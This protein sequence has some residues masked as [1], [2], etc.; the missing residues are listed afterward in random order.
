LETAGFTPTDFPFQIHHVDFDAT[1][2]SLTHFGDVV[3][4][5]DERGVL[6]GV[7]GDRLAT[8]LFELS[9]GA[10]VTCV[11]HPHT[12][13][14]K[15][16]V[17]FGAGHLQL[18]NVRRGQLLHAFTGWQSP[19]R[20]LAQ[21]PA[22]DV[23]GVGLEDGRILLHNLRLDQTVLSFSQAAAVT[24]LA[25]R[26]DEFAWLASGDATGQIALWSLEKKTLLTVLSRAHG[27]GGAAEV[28][29]NA[30]VGVAGRSRP[31]KRPLAAISNDDN[32]LLDNTASPYDALEIESGGASGGVVGLTFLTG[33]P[34]LVSNGGDNALKMWLCEELSAR[35]LRERTGHAAPP[36]LV[37]FYNGGS[38]GG[39]GSGREVLT[40]SVDRSVRM[41]SLIQD[42]QS[43]ELSQGKLEKLSKK[44]GVQVA[45]LKLPPVTAIAS[46]AVRERNWDNVVTAHVG[47]AEAHLWSYV[48][49]RLGKHS[50]ACTD[51]KHAAGTSGSNVI[52][53]V[54]M[55]PCGSFAFLGSNKGWLDKYNVQSGQHRGV[56]RK[57][58]SGG[59][60]H[61]GAMTFVVCDPLNRYIVTGASDGS[62][63]WWRQSDLK[64]L[65]ESVLDSA[66][67]LGVLHDDGRLLAVACDDLVV[68]VF[69]AERHRLVRRL[70]R[71][72]G[73]DDRATGSAAAAAATN[74]FA[75]AAAA[76]AA[77]S[78]KG[79][80]DQAARAWRDMPTRVSS[81][82]FSPDSRWLVVASLDAVRVYDIAS[83]VVVDWFRCLRPVTSVSFSPF[84]DFLATT[85]ANHRAVFLWANVKYFSN[86]PVRALPPVPP[87]AD[88]PTAVSTFD[89]DGDDDDDDAVDAVIDGAS[90]AAAAASAAADELAAAKRE[91]AS[92][93]A[94]QLTSGLVTLS[95]VPRSHWETL[96]Q[97]DIIKQRNRP[98][99]A[100]K[101]PEAAPFFLPTLPGLQP[102]FVV[103]LPE[104]RA[105]DGGAS[106]LLDLG[107]LRPRSEFLDLLLKAESSDD[108]DR[109]VAVLGALSPSKVDFELR[110]L[111]GVTPEAEK[112]LQSSVFGSDGGDAPPCEHCAFL[113]FIVAQL[114]SGRAFELCQAW[115]ALFL[116][117]HAAD[118]AANAP[119]LQ[120]VR[121][122][123]ASHSQLWTRIEELYFKS[124][125]MCDFLG[126]MLHEL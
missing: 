82:A 39:F 124:L 23:V 7:S 41:F 54:A 48:N 18:W 122:V 125:A 38:N 92:Q 1:I 51:P 24:A 98:T 111:R 69:D 22:L 114:A 105:D 126:G 25:F 70:W 61:H 2:L 117:I 45:Q 115:L 32:A 104:E 40:A 120:L 99:E 33:E 43:V 76:A 80:S 106:R 65:A 6:R 94:E 20:C 4:V 71:D 73:A 93:F 112:L 15:L 49:R 44:T 103:E 113:R 79:A 53:C 37:Q 87:F 11:L 100:A 95:D 123:E 85:H 116:K 91:Q 78:G 10:G 74:T 13:V 36:S 63:R 30:T 62:I 72:G 107:K 8:P 56:A 58:G 89:G 26:T 9:C 27:L 67:A 86:V 121:R 118:L 31:A 81:M 21:S 109:V 52:T 66:P 110:A 88:M 60:A 57:G 102:K 12:Y 55:S 77:A 19:V 3:V 29:A 68:R 47:R 5:L 83:G 119:A 84:G 90:G 28:S 59:R 75:A 108:F 46:V 34:V 42:Q 101:A 14:N 17:G 35:L 97:L 16:L 96:A 50:L 64:L